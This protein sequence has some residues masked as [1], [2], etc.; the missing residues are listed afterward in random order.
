MSILDKYAPVSTK[1]ANTDTIHSMDE[2]I[3]V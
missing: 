2:N 1:S 3:K